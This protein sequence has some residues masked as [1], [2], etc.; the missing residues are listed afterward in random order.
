[1]TLD[2]PAVSVA[3]TSDTALP[4]ILVV[5]D[6]LT[7]VAVISRDLRERYTLL[8]ARDGDV[9]GFRSGKGRCIQGRNNNVVCLS[10]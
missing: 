6:S 8:H 5:E 9:V 3:E 4:H 1:M 10:I 7:S 2:T